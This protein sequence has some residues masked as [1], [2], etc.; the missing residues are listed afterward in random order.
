MNDDTKGRRKTMSSPRRI[1]GFVLWVAVSAAFSGCASPGPDLGAGSA[2]EAGYHPKLPAGIK[3]FAAAREDLAGLLEN[4]GAALDLYFGDSYFAQHH[5]RD[6]MRSEGG[7]KT[8]EEGAV[9]MSVMYNFGASPQYPLDIETKNISVQESM[10]KESSRLFVLY[11]DLP[12]LP[13]TVSENGETV[14]LGERQVA[15]GRLNAEEAHRIADDLFFMQQEFKKIKEHRVAHFASRAAQYRALAVKPTMSEEQ[16]KY[17]V[18]ANA[19]TQRKDYA[20]AVDFYLKALDV[21]PVAYPGAYFN[22]ALLSARM[23]RY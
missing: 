4:R 8:I 10:L 7:I 3:T 6:L 19:M 9:P 20:R 17:V 23:Q 5:L 22:L 13:I 15:I 21:D 16:R 2:P 11:A 18:Q 14:L 12:D 1:L